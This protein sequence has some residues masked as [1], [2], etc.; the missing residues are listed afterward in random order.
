M[1]LNCPGGFSD[2]PY[3]Q[4]ICM[5]QTYNPVINAYIQANLTSIQE[6]YAER[7]CKFI[8]LPYWVDKNDLQELAIYNS[9]NI[10]FYH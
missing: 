2:I 8:Y 3:N 10:K 4:I 5:E 9:A 7:S 1:T 6:K